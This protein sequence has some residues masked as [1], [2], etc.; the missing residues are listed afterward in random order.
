MKNL[1]QKLKELQSL[2]LEITKTALLFLCLGV[3]V[4]LLSDDTL[5]GWDPVGNIQKSSA[6]IGV[7][8]LALLYLLY[9]KKK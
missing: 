5:F 8:A 1:F 9:S 2:L 7:L 4:Q 3:V 6:F